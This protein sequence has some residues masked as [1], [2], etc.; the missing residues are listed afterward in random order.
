MAKNLT[1]VFFVSAARTNQQHPINNTKI[2]Y[3]I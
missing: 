2:K 3:K 1:K